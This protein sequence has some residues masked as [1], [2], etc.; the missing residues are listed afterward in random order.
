MAVELYPHNI[1]TYNN[2]IELFKTGN[3]VGV[4]Q[5]TGTG[6]SFL[7]LKWIE[8]HPGENIA[9]LSPSIEIFNQLYRYASKMAV[10]LDENVQFIT[11]EKLNSMSLKEIHDLKVQKIVLDEFHRAGAEQWGVSI[12]EFISINDD[13]QMLGLTATPVRYL[14]NARNMADELFNGR[15]AREMMLGEAVAKGILPVP[16]Y[17]PV[18]YD[19]DGRL[20]E[21]QEE[22]EKVVD[23]K[24]RKELENTLSSLKKQLEN[25]YGVK[26]IFGKYMSSGCGK[27]VVFCRNIAHL[28][29]MKLTMGEWLSDVCSNVHSYVTLAVRTD[30]DSQVNDF[31]NDKED[32]V[33]KLLFSV[34]RLNEGLHIDDVDGVIMLRPTMSPIIY[35]QQMG[36]ALSGEKTHSPIIFDMVNNYQNVLI[37]DSDGNSQNAFEKELYDAVQKNLKEVDPIYFHVFEKAMLFNNIL[38][39]LDAFLAFE[40]DARW[41]AA[42]E[43]YKNFKAEYGREPK[44]SE[45]YKGGNIG[46][47]A[48]IQRRSYN[49]GELKKERENMLREAGFEFGSLNDQQWNATFE[50]YN[51]FKTE[52]G[53]EPNRYDI[54]QGVKIGNWCNTQR[55]NYKKQTLS[56]EHEN[57]LC[58]IGFEFDLLNK[59]WDD[60]ILLYQQFKAEFK[61]EPT[62]YDVYH[63]VRIGVW[64][65]TNKNAFLKGKLSEERINL[66]LN[67]GFNF[68]NKLDKQWNECFELYKQ[69]KAEF[70]HEPKQSET[71]HD[72]KIGHWCNAQRN[73]YKSGKLSSER[74]ILLREAGFIFDNLLD[75]RWHESFELYKQFKAEFGCEPQE[76]DFYQGVSIGRWCGRQKENY[77][78]G[79][80]NSERE[81]LLREAGFV[82]DDLLDKRWYEKFNLYKQ[83]KAEYNREPKAIE[84]YKNVNLG[85][86]CII[87]RTNYYNG[88]LSK[89][90]EDLLRK[91]GFDFESQSDKFK[92]QWNNTFKL[93]KRFKLEFGREPKDRE[94]YQ[95]IKL[96]DWY[97]NQKKDYKN[98]ELSKERE[99][100]LREAGCQFKTSH[101]SRWNDC[102]LLYKRFKAEFGREPKQKETYHDLKIGYWCNAQKQSYKKGKL[103]KEREELLQEAGFVF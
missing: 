63:G 96:G 97:Q 6:K 5:P 40:Q 17:V 92:N 13:A 22:V 80:L 69:F 85:A 67:A 14:D 53:R 50:L 57:M 68:D 101:D 27:Y 25:A 51:Q 100:M 94:L 39:Q 66:L 43:F 34:D 46:Q 81:I 102:Y 98:G 11:Y 86:W 28:E 15:L 89:E 31:I 10:S 12:R 77:I 20:K 38:N 99:Q 48:F 93:Y 60:K 75:K 49:R 95:G 103:S 35:L 61:R 90:R 9:V 1:E 62:R 7:I 44:Y 71:Y 79:Q 24:K 42:F 78:N 18:W 4:V 88:D 26:E 55:Q 59:Q 84:K 23:P 72:L 91:A 87:Q 56:K 83:F 2:I 82:F 58:G 30:K 74:E 41:N 70:G 19:I 3:R 64:L 8:D 54:Y 29:E 52:Y 65:S 73:A 37:I 36:R 47:W 45:V 33:I 21:Y 16:T 76:K 32:G